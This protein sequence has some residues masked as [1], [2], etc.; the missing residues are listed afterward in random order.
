MG[1]KVS[2]V[3]RPV[4]HIAAAIVLSACSFSL[5][6]LEEPYVPESPPEDP[7]Y[8]DD[9][10][11][12]PTLDTAITV[13]LASL[14]IGLIASSG[15]SC[16]GDGCNC[17]G[18]DNILAG[19]FAAAG[20]VL[21]VPAAIYGGAAVV[22][23]RRTSQCRDALRSH[24]AAVRADEAKRRLLHRKQEADAAAYRRAALAR[25]PVA[26][27]V[28]PR[29]L[30][31]RYAVHLVMPTCGPD[32]RRGV[33]ILLGDPAV[34]DS[35]AMEDAAPMVDLEVSAADIIAPASFDL[36]GATVC[37]G[38]AE[39]CYTFGS[40]SVQFDTFDAGTAAAGSFTVGTGA[41]RLQGRFSATWCT[42]FPA[43]D[44]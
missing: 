23:Y 13:G 11:L 38:A 44:C 36:D 21:L 2:E 15:C 7:P 10:D 20:I 41:D 35:C 6:T 24:Q 3:M 12:K 31:S 39:P 5:N 22:G 34:D 32:G 33:R 19:L 25:P 18:S 26:P 42:P 14:S 28:V 8:C 17:T 4:A 9:S 40:S 1:Q 37:P 30:A 29:A 27:P 16:T 43:P